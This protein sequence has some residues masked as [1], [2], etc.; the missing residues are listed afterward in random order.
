VDG[1]G[2]TRRE[3]EDLKAELREIRQELR[4]TRRGL[5]QEIEELDRD[6]SRALGLAKLR[7]DHIEQQQLPGQN[8][9]IEALKANW[10]WLWGGIGFIVFGLFLAVLTAAATGLIGGN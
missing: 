5:R 3:F 6:G 10:K 7:I 9:E 1:N 8:R 2:V 4:D